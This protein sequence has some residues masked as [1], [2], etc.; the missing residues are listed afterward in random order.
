ML[1]YLLQ[2]ETSVELLPQRTSSNSDARHLLSV[3]EKLDSDVRVLIDCGASILE[4]NNKEVAETWLEMRNHDI[5]AVVF[6]NDEEL[7][8]L[9]RTGRIESFQTSSFAKHL[10][11]T[12]AFLDE[13]H[14]RGTDMR[15]PRH[16][17]AAVTLGSQLTKDRLT[18]ACMRMRK[19][20]N[21]QA[22]TFIV[23]EEVSAKIRE[24]TGKSLDAPIEV[25]DVLCWSI[26]ETWEDLKKSMP[27]WAVQG[28]RFES[29]RHLLHGAST[30]KDQ[31]KGFLE[32]EAQGL[33]TRYKPRTKDDD[34]LTQLSSWDMSN[35]NIAQI[36]SRCRDFEAM[37]F[38]SAA[39]SEEQERELSPEIEE[40]RQIERPPRMSAAKH[41]LH[42][43]LLRLVRF[44]ELRV[45]SKAFEPAFKA[46]RSTSAAKLFD[47]SGFPSFP[48][49]L[50]VT[51]DFMRTVKI[52]SGSTEASFISDSYQRPVQ[53]I[54]SALGG[55]VVRNL[56]IISP[57]EANQVL[58]VLSLTRKVTLHL[59]SPR[60][61]ASFASLDKLELYNVG[62]DFSPNTIS[63]SL[64]MQLNLFAGSLY[65][66][67]F[68]EYSEICDFLGLLR[69]KATDGQQVYA[70]GFINPPTGTWGLSKSPVPFLRA[71]LMKIRREG[72]GVEKTHMGKIL[73][74]VRLEERDFGPDA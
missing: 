2:D 5:Q 33:E 45:N 59:F 43:D 36:V 32:A 69:T 3:I 20:G 6:F 12:V 61:N 7:S 44:G 50:L 54:L 39:L 31:A 18:Q 1:G 74:G 64:T 58:P 19:L 57:Y 48:P 40:E 37:G 10:D 56:I 62:H 16:Y 42:P 23:P 24:R 41:E 22:V 25:S 9:D 13:A 49:D 70:D 35:K 4:Q 30:T 65:L 53:F 72:E 8:V 68:A 52:P 28:Q 11:V 21:G 34:G 51:M 14:S 26:G 73:N 66:R 63:R 29:H 71:L 15:L 38:G 17:R 67:S 27:L 46:L 47:L 55:S 60:F